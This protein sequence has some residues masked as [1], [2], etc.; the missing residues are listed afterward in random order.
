MFLSH[1]IRKISHRFIGC[2]LLTH[3]CQAQ[4]KLMLSGNERDQLQITGA[5]PFGPTPI[6]LTTGASVIIKSGP[7]INTCA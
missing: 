6:T 3:L 2:P 1:P 7:T 5:I 4:L